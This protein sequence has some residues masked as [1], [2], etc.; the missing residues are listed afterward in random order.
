M[1]TTALPAFPAPGRVLALL[2]AGVP[3]SLLMD[4]ARPDPRSAE[5]YAA[6]RPPRPR[7][8]T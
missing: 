7:A 4:L 1:S 2:R 5:I 6:E 8:A 3:L